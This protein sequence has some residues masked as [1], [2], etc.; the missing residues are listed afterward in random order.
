MQPRNGRL[1]FDFAGH[2]AIV[3][4][5]C[6]GIGRA[7][8][9]T[10]ADAG[11]EVVVFDVDQPR[12]Y[13]DFPHRFVRVNVTEADALDRSV[14]GLAKP[15][16]LLVNNAGITRDRSLVKM[17]DVE[18]GSVLSVNLTGGFNMIRAVA[19]AMMA[20]GYG[21]IVNITSI[22]GLRG[23]FGQ[24][25]YAAAKAGLVGLT[26]TAAREF[27]KKGITVNAVAPGMVMTDMARVLP[28]EVLKRAVDEAALNELAHPQD[29]SS[30]VLFLLS[31]AARAITGEV[32]RVDAGQYI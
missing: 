31:N 32:L 26:K 2:C 1:Q 28:A 5:G 3:T 21:R 29:I 7:I 14:A 13:K 27:G 15:A 22:N 6:R 25:N 17:S 8:A 10:L 19:P 18:W 30:A 4:G 24:A 20:A 12:D 9:D 16:S 11:A 23:K